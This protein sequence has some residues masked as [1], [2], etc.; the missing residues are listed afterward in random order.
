MLQCKLATSTIIFVALITTLD[1]NQRT[2]GYFNEAEKLI[3]LVAI[4]TK[5]SVNAMLRNYK[6][7]SLLLVPKLPNIS[8]SYIVCITFLFMSSSNT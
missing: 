2:I 3:K 8:A 1:K 6:I 7:I 5:V 4:V